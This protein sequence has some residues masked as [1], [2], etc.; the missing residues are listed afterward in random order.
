MMEEARSAEANVEIARRFTE[1]MA[2]GDYEEA[3]AMVAPDFTVDDTD[4]P[5]STGADSFHEW[6]GRWDAAFESWRIEDLEVRSIA[7]DR[8]LSLFRIY[9][10][11]TGSGVE[12]ARDD[13]AIGEFRDG[14]IV[15]IAYYNDQ[16]QA[17]EAAGLSE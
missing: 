6:I 14:K 12:L 5:E 3:A 16:A 7:E 9:A 10:R 4:I 2:G 15:R 11:G 17:L 8:T 13:A 1:S